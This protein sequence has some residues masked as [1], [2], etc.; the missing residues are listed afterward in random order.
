MLF[1]NFIFYNE[2]TS[3][4]IS[5][6]IKQQH[7]PYLDRWLHTLPRLVSLRVLVDGQ[8]GVE[9]FFTIRTL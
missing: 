3:C 4:S 1:Q 9:R 6:T 2:Q 8:Q 5:K 7:T